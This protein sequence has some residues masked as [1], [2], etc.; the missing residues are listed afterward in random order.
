MTTPPTRQTFA[1][2][3]MHCASCVARLE[4][5]LQQL[6]HV[7]AVSVNLATE[8]ATVTGDVSADS[9]IQAVQSIGY[10]AHAPEKASS[11]TSI[12]TATVK[13][14]SVQPS[15]TNDLNVTAA[16]PHAA[17]AGS[18]DHSQSAKTNRFR[19]LFASACTIPLF[20][21]HML[22][23]HFPGSDWLQFALATPVLFWAGQPIFRSAW[24]QLL[25]KE[26]TMDTL[27][28]LGAGLSWLYS[29]SLLVFPKALTMPHR[30]HDLYFETGAMIITLILIGRYLEA[31]ARKQ[32]GSAIHALMQL[33]PQSAW[34]QRQGE[35]QEVSVT[36]IGVGETILVRPGGRIPLDG[37]VLTG[38][39]HANE[40]MMT[41]ESLPVA[42]QEGAS[43]LAGSLLEAGSLEIR[44]THVSQETTLAHM[45]TLVEQAQKEKPP[46][47][48]LADQVA[49]FFVPVVLFLALL[50]L[51]L[52][53]LN[54]QPLPA[55]IAATV[56]VLVIAC[57]CALGL[58]T[59]TAIQVGLGRGAELGILIQDTMGLELA[60]HLDVLVFDKT[61]TLTEGHPAVVAFHNVS[62]LPDH[63]LLQ[64]AAALELYSEHPLASAFKA[65]ATLENPHPQPTLVVEHFKNHSGAG[66]SGNVD[67][68]HILLG[69][70]AWI[71]DQGIEVPPV[72]SH[73]IGKASQKGQTP[74]VMAINGKASAL[75]L[76]ADPLKPIAAEAI[77]NIRRLGIRPL[78]LT[79]DTRETAQTIGQEAGLLP[80]EIIGALTPAEKVS[81]IQAL[82]DTH[83]RVGMV[84]DGIN[85]APALAQAD[86]SIAMG[87]GTDIAMQAAQMTLI[88]GDIGKTVEA[89]RLSR[90]IYSTIRQNLFWAFIYNIIALP[91]AAL[92]YLTPT[93][94]ALAMSFSSISVVLNAL[95]LKR[96]QPKTAATGIPSAL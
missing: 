31:Q 11:T 79:G 94:A 7:Q 73:K 76:I 16:M 17:K 56:S 82:Q 43:V 14:A 34:V 29:I 39:G 75:F 69:K 64:E 66:V 44:V 83:R 91:L 33:Q 63:I 71:A 52:S 53:L 20:L 40:A 19:L 60:H 59:P 23:W 36:E 89:I 28:A 86:V 38:E 92:G 45:I 84:G 46:I 87:T 22:G 62:T 70:P 55:A 80:A 10:Q 68:H 51:T 93:I 41:G 5:V 32:T 81:H 61:G 37:I 67:S 4:N 48:R 15:S 95:R 1:I 6:P 77:Q 18:P 49:G 88:H 50:T 42:K 24:R 27:I 8:Q 35:F 26:T 78:M 74:V 9:I 30:G 58:A 47:Q 54:H 21:I 57:P 13:S 90:A 3:G 96:F 12:P 25:H 72:L 85:D 2:E 65:S